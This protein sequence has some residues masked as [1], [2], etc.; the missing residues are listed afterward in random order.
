ML[1]Y[2]WFLLAAMTNVD[3]SEI[4]NPG[5]VSN[6]QGNIENNSQKGFSII[7]PKR[8][9]SIMTDGKPSV[10][11]SVEGSMKFEANEPKEGTKENLKSPRLPKNELSLVKEQASELA[12]DVFES[13]KA[14]EPKT[15]QNEGTHGIVE[16]NIRQNVKEAKEENL[17][18]ANPSGTTTAQSFEYKPYE[19]K[20]LDFVTPSPGP[21]SY[22]FKSF[23]SKPQTAAAGSWEY[24]P[25]NFSSTGSNAIGTTPTTSYDYKPSTYEYKPTGTGA[26]ATA[27]PSYEYKPFEAQAKASPSYEFKSYDY[28]T[29]SYEYKPQVPS[30]DYKPSETTTAPSY[31][32]SGTT[33]GGSHDYLGDLKTYTAGVLSTTIGFDLKKEKPDANGI[34]LLFGG[35]AGT[36]PSNT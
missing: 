28:R 14:E 27:T 25:Y 10:I 20:P 8:V 19:Y 4:Y 9:E 17:T 33:T 34:N 15:N 11:P 1:E 23:D 12:S 29:P 6:F 26:T 32:Y 21:S 31:G 22:D 5:L 7:K 16:E 24:K 35:S 30:Y 36:G 2:P 18:K 3:E 13:K